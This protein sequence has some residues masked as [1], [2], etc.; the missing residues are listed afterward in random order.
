[1]SYPL[2]HE[3]MNAKNQKTQTLGYKILM[4]ENINKEDYQQ[5]LLFMEKNYFS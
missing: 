3:E 4:E 2:L 5:V 1:M